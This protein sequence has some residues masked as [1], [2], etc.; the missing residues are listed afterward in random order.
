MDFLEAPILN[1]EVKSALK[2][3]S[4]K[5]DK[6]MAEVQRLKQADTVDKISKKI[7]KKPDQQ[8]QN[9]N[10][11]T[12]G[13]QGKRLPLGWPLQRFNSTSTTRRL[14]FRPAQQQQ[15]SYNQTMNQRKFRQTNNQK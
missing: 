5:R 8:N 15:Q 4:L 7:V 6:Y 3:N 1:T 2:E 14:V 11:N 12:K 13:H 10:L 9:S